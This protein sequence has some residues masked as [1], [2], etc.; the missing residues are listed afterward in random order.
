VGASD[1]DLQQ[2]FSDHGKEFDTA[3]FT[4]GVYSSEQAAELA[5]TAVANGQSFSSVADSTTGGGPQGCDVLFSV[6]SELPSS[7]DLGSL[8]INQVSDPI[9]VSNGEYLLVQITSRTP[10][11]FDKVKSVVQEAVEEAGSANAQK[12]VAAAERRSDVTLDPRYGVW[13]SG[14]AQILTPLTPEKTDV[15]N[16][17]ANSVGLATSAANPFGG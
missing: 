6:S 17:S 3:C 4:V 2:Y 15:P 9:A 12:A 16:A 8:A 7:A 1:A 5:G 10:S 13:V 14:V 11:S